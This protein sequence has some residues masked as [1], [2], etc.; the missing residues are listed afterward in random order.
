MQTTKSHFSRIMGVTV[1]LLT[2]GIALVSAQT[3]DTDGD[4]GGDWNATNNRPSEP[5]STGKVWRC[6][7]DQKYYTITYSNGMQ[8]RPINSGQLSADVPLTID[9]KG[10]QKLEGHWSSGT[11]GGLVVIQGM[12]SGQ[13]SGHMLV[14]INGVA[15]FACNSRKA[16]IIFSLGQPQPVCTVESVSW[17]LLPDMSTSQAVQEEMQ[18]SSQGA[19]TAVVQSYAGDNSAATDVDNSLVGTW[20]NETATAVSYTSTRLELRADGTYTKSFGARPPGM[21]GGVVGAP[22]F[23]D[24][25]TGTWTVAGPMRVQLSGDGRH[26]PYLQNLS[27]LSRR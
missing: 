11:S 5:A 9:K 26:S 1:L 7:F 14:P 16:S 13:I 8:V 24:T 19:E 23:G 6:S 20:S 3:P 25:H 18:A 10:R 15:A 17:T 21:G 12:D 22:T 27:L 4:A 2:G